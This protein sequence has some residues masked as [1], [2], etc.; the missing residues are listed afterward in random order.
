MRKTMGLER[1]IP[2]A[3]TPPI[4]LIEVCVSRVSVGVTARTARCT[5]LL[6]VMAKNAISGIGVKCVWES[7]RSSRAC[8]VWQAPELPVNSIGIVSCVQE[9]N[10]DG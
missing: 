9:S 7:C 3:K 5:A 1:K 2:E 4:Q 6:A 10:F 8:G